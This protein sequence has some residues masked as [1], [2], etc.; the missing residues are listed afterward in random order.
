MVVLPV[1]HGAKTTNILKELT[2]VLVLGAVDEAEVVV[3][4]DE[5]AAVIQIATSMRLRQKL[6]QH[7][8]LITRV[9]FRLSLEKIPKMLL[10]SLR[11]TPS[12]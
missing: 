12:R 7:P 6:R 1:L 2:K 10:R 9:N 11:Q 5:E 3:V 8:V 4:E